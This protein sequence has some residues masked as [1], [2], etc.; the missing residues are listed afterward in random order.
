[1]QGRI[2]NVTGPATV[3]GL[4]PPSLEPGNVAN[5][6]ILDLNSQWTVRAKEFRSKSRNT[7]FE[8][9]ILTGRAMFTFLNGQLT[10]NGNNNRID[11]C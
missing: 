5:I 11:N 7:P 6:S 1:M 2:I 3:L 9:R 10:W 8:G 4:E